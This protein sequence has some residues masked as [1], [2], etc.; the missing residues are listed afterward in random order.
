MGQKVVVI[1]GGNA[2]VDAARVAKRIGSDVTILYRRSR[3]EM[4]ANAWEVDEAEKEG[5]KIEFLVTPSKIFGTNKVQEIECLRM[6]LGKP[7]ASGR[8]RPIP[9]EGS[10]F[11]IPIDNVIVAI[12]QKPQTNWLGKEFKKTKWGTLVINDDTLET[13]VKGVYAGGDV[14]SGPATIIKAVAAGKQAAEAIDA[15]IKSI[16][17]ER[18]EYKEGRPE[19][20]ELRHKE[21]KPR[22]EMPKLETDKRKGFDEVELGFDEETAKR[23]ADRCLNCALCCECLQCDK[24][25]EPEAIVHDLE[26]KILEYDVGAI[27]VATGYDLYDPEKLK[28]YGYGS[29]PDVITSLQ[30]ERLLSASGPTAGDVK[31]IS[32]GKVPKRVV[33]IQCAGSRDKENHLEYCSKICC[34]YTAKHALLY[35][36]RVHD[37]E[38]IIFY[39]DVRTAGKGYEEFYNRVTDEGTI[40]IRGKVSK[41]YQ[42]NGKI[43][44]LG[45]DT[46]SGK[47][48]EV[49]TDMVV[50][51]T[52]MVQTQGSDEFIRKLKIQCDARGFLSEAHPKL[53]P[54]ESLT[55]GIYLAGAAQ[56]PKDI[57]E[58]VAQ[59]SGAAS[60]ALGILTQKKIAFEPTIA[61]VDE[62]LCAGCGI[63]VGVCPFNARELD[64]EK[65][66]VKVIES[67]CQGCG[68]CSAACPSGA[69]QQRNLIDRQ[70][71]EMVVTALGEK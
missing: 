48:V 35:K 5:I 36:H 44:V 34:M 56:G 1:G 2:A 18:K 69:A 45:A 4:P 17:I 8:R 50:L 13:T 26:D 66:V 70:I 37:G 27:V 52:A 42:D 15:N 63:C 30:F 68:S 14:V 32:D 20:E 29:I 19:T 57:P 33:F 7:D 51:A 21:K 10:E 41:V 28:E 43:I 71:E 9:I 61:G 23:E 46:L 67:L 60:K 12:S 3:K 38:P 59:A 25:C 64:K 47:Q 16:K 24:V 6:K 65:M 55:T 22:A 54:V 11:K 49:E 39:I 31:R 58:V 62:D 40:Y 53:R